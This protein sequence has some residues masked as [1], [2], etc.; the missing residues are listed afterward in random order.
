MFSLAASVHAPL[1]IALIVIAAV[2]VVKVVFAR[3]R[4]RPALG[5]RIVVRC[6][7]GHLF[8][9]FWSPWGS[10][11]SIRLGF[12]RFQRCP[13]G[14]HWSLVRPVNESE[15]TDE[16]RRAVEASGP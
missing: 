9:T 14:K 7:K 5:G 11:T 6:S 16:E 3:V 1:W 2:V 12:A 8:R 4:G 13:V 15:L 10:F